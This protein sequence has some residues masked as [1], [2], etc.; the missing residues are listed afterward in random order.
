LVVVAINKRPDVDL[1][2][3]FQINGFVPSAL[4][5]LYR[6]GQ[7]NPLAIQDLGEVN[8]TREQLS[9]IL[10]RSSI[11]LLRVAHS[12]PARGAPELD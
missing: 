9:L 4:A 11:T 10:P 2:T 12:A 5:R 1:P 7:D 3:A 6:F 8:V